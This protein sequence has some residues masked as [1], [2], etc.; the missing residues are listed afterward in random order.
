LLTPEVCLTV[1]KHLIWFEISGCW[2]G[3]EGM[4]YNELHS[5][6]YLINGNIP[7]IQDVFTLEFC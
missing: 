5:S 7:I 1:S 2:G 4:K 3:R 6:Y